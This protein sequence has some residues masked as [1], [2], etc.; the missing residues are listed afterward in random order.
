LQRVRDRS[1]VA[2]P[3]RYELAIGLDGAELDRHERPLKEADKRERALRMSAWL[4]QSDGVSRTQVE[5]AMVSSCPPTT[6]VVPASARV[7]TLPM[8]C[9]GL[10]GSLAGVFWGSWPAPRSLPSRLDREVRKKG[11]RAPPP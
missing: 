8:G 9:L 7:S 6:L 5:G 4:S 10:V 1:I 11:F 3:C 2:G